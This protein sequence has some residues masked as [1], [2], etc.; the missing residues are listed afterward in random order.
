[1]K[2]VNNFRLFESINYGTWISCDE[3][4]PDEN[5]F[6]L[7]Y[8]GPYNEIQKSAPHCDVVRLTRLQTPESSYSS[9]NKKDYEWKTFGPKTYFGQ[10]ISHWMPLPQVPN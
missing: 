3:Q 8:C 1:M 7:G 4:L 10:E 5:E 2:K 9:N 6:I